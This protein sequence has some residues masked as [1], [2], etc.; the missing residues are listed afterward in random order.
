MLRACQLP[1]CEVSQILACHVL[2]MGLGCEDQVLLS[3]NIP[4]D[5]TGASDTGFQQNF[6]PQGNEL[7]AKIAMQKFGTSF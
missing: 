7:E 5:Q 1:Q 3:K 4:A 2:A 6:S